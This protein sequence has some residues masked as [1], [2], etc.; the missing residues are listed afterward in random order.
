MLIIQSSPTLCH[1]MDYSPPGS[2]AMEFSRWEYWNGLPFP[3]P[4]DLP[5]PGIEP[6][7]PA[8]QADSL[9][10]E[11]PGIRCELWKKMSLCLSRVL[12][13]TLKEGTLVMSETWFSC[14]T[15][16]RGSWHIMVEEGLLLSILHARDSLTAK[17]C[18]APL[19][20]SIWMDKSWSRVLSRGQCLLKLV[21]FWC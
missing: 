8:L 14:H 12:V 17:N 15:W 11:P 1:L 6:R 21:C 9:L 3:F 5:D 7:P 10:S 13:C 20:N 19:V 18:S 16:K 2:S 4:G